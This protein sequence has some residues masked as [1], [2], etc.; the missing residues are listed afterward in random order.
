MRGIVLLVLWAAVLV[1]IG[2]LA[3]RTIAGGGPGGVTASVCVL[4]LLALALSATLGN[5]CYSPGRTRR[6]LLGWGLCAT[7]AASLDDQPDEADGC[8]TCPRCRSSWRLG[9]SGDGEPG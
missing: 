4:L 8:R 7:C 2:L 3:V 6:V 1:V 5:F 9:G